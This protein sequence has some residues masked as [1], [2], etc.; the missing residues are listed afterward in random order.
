VESSDRLP[1]PR[2]HYVKQAETQIS[3]PAAQRLLNNSSVNNEII[4]SCKHHKFKGRGQGYQAVI[5]VEGAMKLIMVLPGERAKAMRLQAADILSRYILGED[6]LV[7]EIKQ[8]K[9]IGPVAAC[10]NLAHKAAAK[11]SQYTEMPQASYVYGTKSDAFPG[12]VKIGRSC[13]ITARL[14]SLNTACAPAPHYIVAV[15]P[16]F[17]AVRDEALA[18]T[19]FS[20]SRKEGEF[21]E[22]EPEAVKS[23]FTNHIMAQYQVELAEHI[24]NRQGDC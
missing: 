13:D 21:F 14:A 11:A 20:S 2:A 1:E 9:Q 24:A 16:T 6:S 12:L 15:A 7:E 10:S 4:A 22:V 17:N 18:H 19:F 5:T 3:E 8:N 23:F